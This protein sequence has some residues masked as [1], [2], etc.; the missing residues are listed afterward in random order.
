MRLAVARQRG[1]TLMPARVAN[2]AR[3]IL[4]APPSHGSLWSLGHWSPVFRGDVDLLTISLAQWIWRRA[5]RDNAPP[6][7]FQLRYTWVS[8]CCTKA[9]TTSPDLHYTS[10]RL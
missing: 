7:N 1:Q 9:I 3:T 6:C 8:S 2:A 4:E 10:G 5:T